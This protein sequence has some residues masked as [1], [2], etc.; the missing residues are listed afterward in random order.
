MARATLQPLHAPAL[1]LGPNPGALG[2]R[3]ALGRHH[4]RIRTPPALLHQMAALPV[5]L[6]TRRNQRAAPRP[7]HMDMHRQRRVVVQ[8]VRLPPLAVGAQNP[9]PELHPPDPLIP[10]PIRRRASQRQQIQEQA[11]RARRSSR[12]DMAIA[13]LKTNHPQLTI[14]DARVWRFPKS[15]NPERPVNSQIFLILMVAAELDAQ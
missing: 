10:R 4:Q 14:M 3:L 8:C 5:A 13:I 12:L 11:K 1:V 9:R 15:S 2:L 7:L 6:L